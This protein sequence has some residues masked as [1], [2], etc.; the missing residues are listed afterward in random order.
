MATE[1]DQLHD[2]LFEAEYFYRERRCHDALDP[3]VDAARRGFGWAMEVVA[4]T[5]PDVH[6]YTARLIQWVRAD[7]SVGQACPDHFL[8][9]S[10]DPP[11]AAGR[12]DLPFEPAP[13]LLVV[14]H[15]P[16]D[17]RSEATRVRLDAERD[18][19]RGELRAPYRLTTDP[20]DRSFV[21]E[22]RIAG[23]YDGIDPHPADEPAIPDLELSF[24]RDDCSTSAGFIRLWFRGE[25]VPL[26][27]EV[28]PEL[29]RL[30][31][32]LAAKG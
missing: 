20:A 32:E 11:S 1:T 23:R 22:R 21:L 3:R 16:G 30:R 7:G 31:A 10:P 26:P 4:A 2:D 25:R 13:P 19:C 12:Y 6:G 18:I 15:R 9:V 24:E 8:T 27:H 28:V 29:A 14:Y 17:E 5:R